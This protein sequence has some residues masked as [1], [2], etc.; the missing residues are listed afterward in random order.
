MIKIDMEMPVSCEGCRF[1]LH[2]NSDA[3]CYASVSL[4]E[5]DDIEVKPD[6][7]PLIEDS[8]AVE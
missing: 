1:L 7:C 6:W 8:E 4:Q 3:I 5:M 2:F